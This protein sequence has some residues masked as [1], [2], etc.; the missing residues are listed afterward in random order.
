MGS[1]STGSTLPCCPFS[2]GSIAIST[3]PPVPTLGT[4]TLCFCKAMPPRTHFN[5]KCCKTVAVLLQLE[6]CHRGIAYFDEM[7]GGKKKCTTSANLVPTDQ[8]LPQ[9]ISKLHH[10]KT[11]TC[12]LC[13]CRQDATGTEMLTGAVCDGGR[14]RCISASEE[15]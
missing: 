8:R 7:V 10:G 14:S 11:L 4:Q 5:V 2:N 1:C 3:N 6:H 12:W 9:C 13:C 15:S